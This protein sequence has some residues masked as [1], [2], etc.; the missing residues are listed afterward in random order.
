MWDIFKLT[1]NNNNSALFCLVTITGTNLFG[2]GE[3]I[4]RVFFG[5]T[6]GSIDEAEANNT[7]AVVRVG[8]RNNSM[9]EQVTVRVIAD[10]NAIVESD[11]DAWTYFV[12]GQ[13]LNVQ[14]S[15]GQEGTRVVITGTNLLGGGSSTDLNVTLDGVQAEIE[16]GTVPNDTEITVLM[17]DLSERNPN[18]FPG[19]AYI[20]ADTGA[21]V[22]GGV[23]N[24]L[25]SGQITSFSP[26][27][28]RD[29]TRIVI[30]G[31]NLLGYGTSIERVE[32]AGVVGE[33]I[34]FDGSTVIVLANS[35]PNG[36]AGQIKLYSDTGAVV[37]S[38]NVFTYQQ[39]G[40]ITQV[41]PSFGAEGSG[42]LISGVA[43][44]PATAEIVSVTFGGSEVSRIISQTESTV[45][46][47]VGPAPSVN[48]TNAEITLL[49][50][51]DSFVR[52]AFFSYE[53]F[54]IS[55]VGTNI[56]QDGT[57]IEISLPANFEFDADIMVTV[58]EQPAIVLGIG[59]STV[60]ASVPRARFPGTYEA[61]VTVEN[62]NGLIARLRSGFTYVPEGAIYS[63]EPNE[64]QR[65]TRVALVG[66]NLLGNDTSLSS[67]MVAGVPAHVMDSSNEEV[68]LRILENPVTSP[69]TG[70]IVLTAS[71]GAVIRRLNGFTLVEPGE[72]TAFTPSSGQI[73]TIV[74]IMGTRLLQG[75]SIL[76]V[77]NVTLSGVSAMVMDNQTDTLI[78]VQASDGIG[79]SEGPIEIILSSGAEITSE[80]N[81]T[82]LNRGQI[83][84]VS[85]STGTVGTR[86][87]VTGTNLLGGGQSI[88]EVTLNGVPAAVVQ[89]TI[90]NTTLTV[91]AGEGMPSPTAGAVEIISDTGSIVSEPNSWTYEELGTITNVSPLIG[92]QGVVVS[93][94]GTSLVGSAK[95]IEQCFIANVEAVVSAFS[96]S[97]V[98]CI[99]GYSS[100]AVSGPVRIVAD[101]GPTIISN[102]TF[103]YYETYISEIEPVSGKNGTYVTI[104]G[105]NLTGPADTG[106]TISAVYFGNFSVFSTEV[107]DKDT[108]L[109]R[110]RGYSQNTTD[111]FT[112]RVESTIG[113]FLELPDAWSFS[114]PGSIFNLSPASGLPGEVIAINGS[115]LVTPGISDVQVIVGQTLSFDVAVFNTSYIEFR[116]GVY[117]LSVNKDLQIPFDPLPIQIIASD[118]STVLG[119]ENINFTYNKAGRI[120]SISPVAGGFRSTV[121]ITGENLLNGASPNST[122]T[123][124]LAGIPVEQILELSDSQ[125]VVVAGEATDDEGFSGSVIIQSENGTLTGLS[126]DEWTYLPVLR[127]SDVTPLFGQA[128]TLVT[129]NRL[130]VPEA[131]TVEEVFLAGVQASIEG[132]D[133]RTIT[134]RAGPSNATAAM[135]ITVNF[136]DG[137]VL[138]ILE[139]WRYQP[140]VQ[141]D[142]VSNLVSNESVG[143][144]NTTVVM[145]GMGFQGEDGPD[146]VMVVNVT[147]AGI[148][149]EI[150]SQTNTELR[151]RIRE[152]IDSLGGAISGIVVIVAENGTTFRSSE[153]SFTYLQVDPS[154]I[155][156]SFGQFSTR[157][158]IRGV[159]LLAGGTAITDFRMGGVLAD[160]VFNETN[161]EIVVTAGPS[162]A[163]DTVDI[164]YTV[165]TNAVVRI[166]NS[167]TYL[168]PGEITGITPSSGSAGTVV[169]I[170]GRGM[171]GGGTSATYVR[172]NN[173]P[174]ME[175][176][177]SDPNLI[178]AVVGE[179][180]GSGSVY[181][182]ANTGAQLV[183]GSGVLFQYLTPGTVSLIDPPMGQ[184][185]T[186]VKITGND[187]YRSSEGLR[188]VF[189]AGREAEVLMDPPPTTAVITVTAQRPTIHGNFSGAVVIES[190]QGSIIESSTNFTYLSEGMICS[191]T[192][193]R[194]Q[195][196]TEVL[197]TGENLLGGGSTLVA[198]HLA[199]I[200]AEIDTSSPPSNEEVRVLAGYAG[201]TSMITGDVLLRSDTGSLVRR[202][203]GWTYVEP[204]VVQTLEPSE[205]QH[206][207]YVNITGERLTSGGSGVTRVLFDD[208]EAEVISSSGSLVQVRQGDPGVN[209]TFNTSTVT[210]VS[211]YGGRLMANLS[212]VYLAPSS[213]E[214]VYPEIG[215]SGVIVTV[216]GTNLLGGGSTIERVYVAGIA[217]E[218]ILSSNDSFVA[219]KTGLNPD[220]EMRVGNIT[221]EADTGALTIIVSWTYERECPPGFFGN[222]PANCSSCDEQC[223]TCVGGPSNS[224]CTECVN[225]AILTGNDTMICV[226][227][228]P[229]VSSLDNVC[230]DAC[231]TDQYAR[232]N[233]TENATFC[234]DCSDLCDTSFGCSGPSEAE[235]GRCASY[236]LNGVCVA[237]CPVGYFVNNRSECTPCGDQ[238][239]PEKGCTGPTD[240]DCGECKNVVIQS[241]TVRMD[242]M[243]NMFSVEGDFCVT[244]CPINYY[245]DGSTCQVCNVECAGNCNGPTAFDC[246]SC[247][248]LI[249]AMGACVSSCP[250]DT[251]P[252]NS[253]KVCTRCSPLCLPGAG[254]DG[255]TSRDCTRCRVGYALYEGECVDS[256]P[257][258]TFNSTASIEEPVCQD[259]NPSCDLEL[260]CTGPNSQDCVTESSAFAAGG[261][262]V[263]LVIIFIIALLVAVVVLAA[264]VGWMVYKGKRGNFKIRS[265]EDGAAVELSP[266]YAKT[267]VKESTLPKNEES[268]LSTVSA[269]NPRAANV[270]DD[271]DILYSDMP[272]EDEEGGKEVEKE[273][274]QK[275]PVPVTASTEDLYTDMGTEEPPQ[276]SED[277]TGSMEL[278]TEMTSTE[279]Q[280]APPPRPPKNTTAAAKG[281]ETKTEKQTK[282]PS[283][284]PPRPPS[285]ELY[286]DMQGSIQEVY[287]NPDTQGEEEYTAVSPQVEG[288]TD[289]AAASKRD[290]LLS[291]TKV[292]TEEAPLLDEDLYEDTE[293]AAAEA[294]KYKNRY[295][296][297]TLGDEEHTSE[298]P[299]AGTALDDIYEDTEVA[300]AEAKIY[301][302]RYSSTSL[303]MEPDKPPE[304][305][306]RQAPKKRT[307]NIPLPQTPMEKALSSSSIASASAGSAGGGQDEAES[308]YMLAEGEGPIEESLYEPIPAQTQLIPKP[309]PVPPK[310]KPTAKP[311][312]KPRGKNKSDTNII[313]LPPR[314]KKPKK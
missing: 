274:D 70:D 233:S 101:T 111:R 152:D 243:G 25:P 161:E 212:W 282:Q 181:I 60:N 123:V 44:R 72:I 144:F 67:A 34:S 128:E 153:G 20:L 294:L 201:N 217:V 1:I 106:S 295:S 11:M 118:G 61:D 96:D 146:S 141:L 256:C 272:P 172:L 202:I 86:V 208:I 3:S 185:G 173:F 199:S 156:P 78:Q 157:V 191:V 239:V 216:N 57:R 24:H 284:T 288:T 81:F 249:N 289:A 14:P 12:E 142:S 97:S 247:K 244:D 150:L 52:G 253:S 104:K 115:N 68:R 280:A 192:P 148:S 129:I 300:A 105:L 219:F 112:V 254:C 292:P 43:L 240:F 258:D 262:T 71:T 113:T 50:S 91:V 26:M 177:L 84:M 278:Y 32:V 179:G 200:E 163:M 27:Q 9:D 16:P 260:G 77:A 41:S 205:G 308:L 261:G 62:Q 138:T 207:S 122:T 174:V 59:E 69:V 136:N 39:P 47:I 273:A 298:L 55:L 304:L 109:V 126:G 73:G 211:N 235:C 65:G 310:P 180:T 117:Q 297:S 314:S 63:I 23:Y 151:V 265:P 108:L 110:V 137:I 296:S 83:T 270:S 245:V 130:S 189:L 193:S 203:S 285:P 139:S 124:T 204:G 312:A 66:E 226:G 242:G 227:M 303:G 176:I 221:M 279:I 28:G 19:E 30:T 121:N 125:I 252:D 154:T 307:S 160:A 8:S 287:V 92:Q 248:N 120:T 147:L 80:T 162:P 299:T 17:G 167:W 186:V 187:L 277:A 88:S 54:V 250:V 82:Y 6:E 4:S 131:Y 210:L 29:G 76:S 7:Q 169:I 218:D 85:P 195:V 98:D 231:N 100:V 143:Y 102:Q 140:P 51:D 74:S 251:F 170:T 257:I 168:P 35:A 48:S 15:S 158:T 237:E 75:S 293:V 305:P 286:A 107:I 213:V 246:E 31:V 313:P 171:L 225:F 178:K 215:K 275:K 291:D 183:S 116:P 155:M 268:A 38:V 175:V 259:C 145:E 2:Y 276:R 197:I 222:D 90:T 127:S 149:T 188:R 93:L 311:T 220:G 196:G 271:L 133:N 267:N 206:G 266:R 58:G 114:E 40:V 103:D 166:P 10:T 264:I 89:S 309:D 64:G 281:G 94:T 159:G 36:T 87:V 230:M 269:S 164:T 46:V 79:D 37:S 119:N 21:F 234:Y 214:I 184:V 13:I 229:N 33:F 263:A 49:A 45:S 241:T 290:S 95:S 209:K 232:T 198:I 165:D 132:I 99:A 228:C 135:D 224:H 22:F 238:C 223:K 301:Q 255:P 42:V 56:G 306:Q 236:S 182:E 134:L 283:D 190:D 5:D 302:Q 53:E 18:F 194:G